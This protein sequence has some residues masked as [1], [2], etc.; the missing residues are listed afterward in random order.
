[1][2]FIISIQLN[3]SIIIATDN[4]EFELQ[5]NGTTGF[6]DQSILK[7]YSW[8]EGM[9]TGT[10]ESKVVSRAVEFFKQLNN[11]D[12]TELPHYL[13]L[14]RQIREFEIGI[15]Y[16][17]VEMTKLMCSQ[18][19]LQGAQLYKVERINASQP[20]TLT[21]II[22]MTITVWMFNPNIEVISTDLQNLYA[23][24]KNYEEFENQ[25]DWMN[26]YINR[27]APIYQ[28]Q[29]LQDSFMSQSF[30]IFFQ[31][32]DDYVFGHI[33]NTQNE[34]LKIQEISSNNRS[35]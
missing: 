4:K 13:D 24:L 16:F 17:Q 7:M 18:Y 29:S 31:T 34:Y 22:P 6:T 2:T 35:I 14:S 15:N 25:T 21:A 28:K 1:M 9:I 33:P 32:K 10:G 20:Y 11:L 8:K 30:D 3:D 26:H 5:E 27:I 23:D 12:L 19:T